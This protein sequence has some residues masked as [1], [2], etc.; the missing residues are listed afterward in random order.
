MN[1]KRVFRIKKSFDSGW[2][3][4]AQGDDT[5]FAIGTDRWWIVSACFTKWGALWKAKR[6]ARRS[7]I[8]ENIR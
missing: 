2:V 8:V 4:E 1:E 5:P 7:I 6:L 3:V